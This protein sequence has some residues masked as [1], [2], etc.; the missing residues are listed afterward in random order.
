[1]RNLK[2]RFTLT[3]FE[4][5][6]L[7]LIIQNSRSEWQKSPNKRVTQLAFEEVESLRQAARYLIKYPK[8]RTARAYALAILTRRANV[9]NS[10]A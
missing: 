6:R 1:M 9:G 10:H 5:D 4:F 7:E 8:S 2:P 3:Q